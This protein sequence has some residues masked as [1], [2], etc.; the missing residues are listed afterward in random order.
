MIELN[1]HGKN[2][3]GGVST[4]EGRLEWVEIGLGWE[5]GDFLSGNDVEG[6]GRG[7]AGDVW[8]DRVSRRL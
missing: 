2:W 6:E 1:R 5:G 8:G 3:E 4:D 7:L